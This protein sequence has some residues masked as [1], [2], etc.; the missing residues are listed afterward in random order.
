[1]LHTYAR[2]NFFIK[3]ME[4]GDG[5]KRVLNKKTKSNIL[6]FII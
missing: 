2:T 3:D 5:W 4:G 1:M 6:A